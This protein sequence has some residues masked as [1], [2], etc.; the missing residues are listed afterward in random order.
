[1]KKFISMILAIAILAVS[2][3][4]LADGYPQQQ[5]LPGGM[6]PQGSPMQGGPGQPPS[7][8]KP[9]DL[10][11]LPDGVAPGDLPDLPDGAQSGD[12]PEKP[13]GQQPGG[14]A[15]QMI[16]FD[17]MVK[18]GVITQDTCDRIRAYMADHKPANLPGAQA[19]PGEKPADPPAAND[20]E[21]PAEG[22]LLRELL[23]AGVITQEE[24]DALTGTLTAVE[25]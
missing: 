5:G 8:E 13:D 19:Q 9:D 10:P 20:S 23:D 4:A 12:P 18:E 2:A 15:P 21:A 17:A 14:S 7:G 24:Y 11:D 16:D 22:G 3:A 1:M 6:P 25:A